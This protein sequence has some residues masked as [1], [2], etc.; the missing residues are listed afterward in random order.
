MQCSL[1][2]DKFVVNGYSRYTQWKLYIR[3]LT[4]VSR[5]TD[6]RHLSKEKLGSAQAQDTAHIKVQINCLYHSCLDHRW[7]KNSVIS[8][9]MKEETSWFLIS[10]AHISHT[11]CAL[12]TRAKL[13]L[14][15][16]D[17][18]NVAFRSPATALYHPTSGGHQCCQSCDLKSSTTCRSQYKISWYS[19]LGE[20]V[21]F[22]LYILVHKYLNSS[23]R[24]HHLSDNIRMT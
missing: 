21:K 20:R 24:P 19:G 4:A 7:T 23:T 6:L 16:I 1:S 10:N 2:S 5:P 18:C 11:G 3:A 17:Y 15:R 12:P 9:P 22:K 13:I 14:T 8:I